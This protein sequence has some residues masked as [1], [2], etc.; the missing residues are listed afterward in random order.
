MFKNMKEKVSKLTYPTLQH[1]YWSIKLNIGYKAYTY[2]IL[3]NIFN[4]G[5]ISKFKK[6]QYSKKKI[7][8]EFPVDMHIYTLCPS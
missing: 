5:Q 2:W 7:E 4:F 3:G 8:S 6:E 1:W